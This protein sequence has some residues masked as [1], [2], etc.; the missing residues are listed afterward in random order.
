MR[1]MRFG[2][3]LAILSFPFFGYAWRAGPSLVWWPILIGSNLLFAG[4]R[5]MHWGKGLNDELIDRHHGAELRRRD[6]A[7]SLGK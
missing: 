2:F 3:V 1:Y 7:R 6:A 5:L 4:P